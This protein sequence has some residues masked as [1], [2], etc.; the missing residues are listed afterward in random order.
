VT[1]TPGAF[2]KGQN[3][4][5]VGFLLEPVEKDAAGGSGNDMGVVA[6]V[7]C[8]GADAAQEG[9]VCHGNASISTPCIWRANGGFPAAIQIVL[10]ITRY[11]VL[12]KEAVGSALHSSVWIQVG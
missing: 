11:S 2:L 4:F 8:V 12:V 6:G 7:Q 1:G 5:G 9:E 10:V 3:T